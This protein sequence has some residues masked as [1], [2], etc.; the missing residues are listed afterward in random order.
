MLELKY[1]KM[2]YLYFNGVIFSL[3]LQRTSIK[4]GLFN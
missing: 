2:S 1:L 3:V 4:N